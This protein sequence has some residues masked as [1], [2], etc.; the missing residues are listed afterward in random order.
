MITLPIYHLFIFFESLLLNQLHNFFFS[1]I[2]NFNLLH[3]VSFIIHNNQHGFPSRKYHLNGVLLNSI[4]DEFLQSGKMIQSSSGAGF[5]NCI[6]VLVIAQSLRQ[7]PHKK[8]DAEQHHHQYVRLC[9]FVYLLILFEERK[10]N[11]YPYICI[12]MIFFQISI[13]AMLC[14]FDKGKNHYT[15]NKNNNFA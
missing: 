7:L 11:I 5:N 3:F 12:Y 9:H 10:N 14:R 15:Q 4:P 2:G 13:Q 6:V 8:D 1:H